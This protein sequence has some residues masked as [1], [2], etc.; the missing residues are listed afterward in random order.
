MTYNQDITLDLN[1]NTSYVVIGAKQFDNGRTITATILSNGQLY[2]IDSGTTALYRIRKPS[3]TGVWNGATL[4]SSTSKVVFTL[5][6]YDLNEVGRNFVDISFMNGNTIL[7]TVSFIIDVQIVPN[8][9]ESAIPSS[10]IDYFHVQEQLKFENDNGN[11]LIK[12]DPNGATPS[13]EEEL[14]TT[15]AIAS[16]FSSTINYSKRDYVYYN[17]VLYVFTTDHSAGTWSDADVEEAKLAEAIS[18]IKNT[19]AKEFTWDNT[20]YATETYLS[21][22]G[23]SWKIKK[24][25]SLDDLAIGTLS[26]KDIFVTN[27]LAPNGSFTSGSY[28]PWTINSGSPV[29]SDQVYH[30]RGYSLK[31]F[32]STSTQIKYTVSNTKGH[33]YFLIVYANVPR[34]S[35]GLCGASLGS[36]NLTARTSSTTNGWQFFWN[37]WDATSTANRTLYVGT[38]SSADADC[39]IDDVALLDMT[40]LFPS[41]DMAVSENRAIYSTKLI[42]A[43]QQYINI[44]NDDNYVYARFHNNGKQK[45]VTSIL[46]AGSDIKRFSATRMA[47]RI[48]ELKL[49]GMDTAPYEKMLALYATN[50]SVCILPEYPSMYRQQQP[51]VIYSLNGDSTAVPASVTKVVSILTALPYISSIKDHYTITSDDIHTGSGNVFQ[52]GDIVTIEDLLYAM[53]LPS[54]NTAAHALGHYVGAIILNNQSA[55]AS[56][57]ET[58]FVAAM[59]QFMLDIG[60]TDSTFVSPSGLS[61][62]GNQNSTTTNDLLKVGIEA[63]SWDILNRI[64]N[65]NSYTVN[66]TGTNARQIS[67][68]STVQSEVLED[69]YMILGGKTGTLTGISP[70]AHSLLTITEP[71]HYKKIF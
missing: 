57:C 67:L 56:A 53:M 66:V 54:S 25:S 34:R 1:T 26:Y 11:L 37:Y 14:V 31:C 7:S 48:A 9:A 5:N 12:L 51:E 19:L 55:T 23:V 33:V 20:T 36:D 64:W 8:L 43:Y 15:S 39:Y 60:A 30:S 61:S 27:N 42:E 38:M 32:G 22:A 50:A 18:E 4:Y 40:N 3:G 45:F 59:N 21:N 62:G 2:S 52:A 10:L 13:G 35:A 17:N 41:I 46:Y 70:E 16:D 29:I 71:K 63:A 6:S 69:E 24:A 49:L 65:I 58:A 47:L 28:S 44:L 68:T